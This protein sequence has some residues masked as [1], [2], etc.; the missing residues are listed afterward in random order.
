[1]AALLVVGALAVVTDARRDV[2][3]WVAAGIVVVP[4]L[5]VLIAVV[6]RQIAGDLPMGTAVL[7][8]IVAIS[9]GPWL[10]FLVWMLARAVMRER[11]ARERAEERA[12][13]AV[14]LHDSVLQSLSLIQKQ[15]GSPG[16]VDRL[17]RHA[18]RELRSFLYD[19]RAASEAADLA[20]ALAGAMADLED[21]F[22]I[23]VELVMVGTRPLDNAAHAV[24]GAVGEAVAN[25]AR[26]AGVQQVSVF[27]NMSG[28]GILVRVRDRGRG[29]DSEAEFGPERRGIRDSII[30]RMDQG[31]GRATVNS[32][33]GSGTEIELRVPA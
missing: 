22:A 16:E 25:A 29:F 18:E 11:A 13:L 14:H 19:P 12:A 5:V 31:G 6:I 10:F 27:A 3:F 21:R 32:T 7:M 15:S 24:L 23:R 9:V 1:L 8:A 28:S 4:S 26:H 30:G 20:A 33:L 17:S 2:L